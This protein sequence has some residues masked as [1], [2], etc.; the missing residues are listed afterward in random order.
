M[1]YAKQFYLAEVSSFNLT[2]KYVWLMSHGTVHMQRI[3]NLHM[4]LW[5][6]NVSSK[7][8]QMRPYKSNKRSTY[9]YRVTDKKLIPPPPLTITLV[10]QHCM[11][12]S[13]PANVII[14]LPHPPP[15]TPVTTLP[16]LKRQLP[17]TQNGIN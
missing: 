6:T 11:Q 7:L 15:H 5:N 12:R 9:Y 4:E 14:F 2:F 8:P 3:D 1:L 13:R 16:N 10:T 17:G